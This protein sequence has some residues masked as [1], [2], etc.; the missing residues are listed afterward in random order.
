MNL[1]ADIERKKKVPS[2]VPTPE[3]LFGMFFKW[4]DLPHTRGFA[5]IPYI[6]G[7]TEPLTRLLRRHDMLVTNKP[8]RTLQEEFPARKFRQEQD[9]QC[10]AVHKIPCSTCSLSYIGET[11]RSF[12][13]RTKEHTK[14]SN[15]ANHAWSKNHQ[16]DFDNALIIDKA[17]YCH[18][19]TLESWHTAK[20]V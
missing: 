17:N 4:V 8:V 12:H 6:N 9:D 10:N 13:T 18:L 2:P 3:E 19:K 5:T 20:T 7:L 11:G 14:C 1:I 15:V 16:I